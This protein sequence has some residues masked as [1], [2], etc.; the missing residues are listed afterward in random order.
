VTG[1]VSLVGAG[2]WNPELLTLAGRERLSRADVVIADYLVNPALFVHCKPGVQVIQRQRGPKHGARILQ[3]D[4]DRMLVEHAKAGHYVVRLKGGDPCVF[5]RGGEEAEIL[6]EH[7]IPF[8]L[9]PGV[10]S[11]VAAP[12]SAGI[13]ITHRDHTPA[14]T[15]VSG[16]E[17]YD[18]AGLAVQWKHL[19]R[20]AGTIVMM[21]G[22][23]NLRDNARRLI[24]AGRS[25]DTPSAM[26]RWGTRGVQRTLVGTL[27]TI[28]DLVER[29]GL[30]P[31]A[32][33]VVGE[34]VGLRDKL[35]WLDGRPLFGRR[36]VVTRSLRQAGTLVQMLAA[37]GADVA[38]VPCLEIVPPEDPG[39]LDRAVSRI[40]SDHDGLLLTS[41]NGVAALFDALGR[42]GLDA[43]SLAGVRIAVVGPGTAEACRECHVIPDLVAS[44]RSSEGLVELLE[45][46]DLLAKRW[47]HVRAEA[48]RDVLGVAIRGAGGRYD[49]VV[50]YRTRRPDLPALL[51]ESLGRPEKGGEGMDAICFAS[52]ETCRSFL[53]IVIEAL[54]G[55]EARACIDAAKIVTIGPVTTAA[56]E[57]L[58]VR[59]DATASEASDEGMLQAVLEVLGGGTDDDG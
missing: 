30:R 59:V 22:V 5:G 37:R 12:E 51:L 7:G 6:H 8:E 43:R 50:G 36:V 15:F 28:A 16:F 1:F 41:P 11:S 21:M 20:A 44:K 58:G 48:G 13:P 57:A 45:K 26:I 34:V 40:R 54:G 24:D 23:G 25:P 35:A 4:I 56:V 32:V 52:G 49:M 39:A 14:V 27:A 19:A 33:L 42:V 17:A 55:E 46:N 18:K 31:P 38:H 53:Q 3:K 9:V 29:D 10:S 47:L 2:P